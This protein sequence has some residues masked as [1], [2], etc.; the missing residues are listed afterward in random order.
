MSYLI[1]IVG[2]TASGKTSTAI[3][4]ARAFDTVVLSADSRQ[5]YKEMS[6]GTAKPN[7]V[8][9]SSAKHYFIDNLSI[10]D[11]YS[12]GNYEREV[13]ALLD[14]LF[15]E[16]EVIVM[17][18]GSGLFINAV[19]YGLD[20]FPDVPVEIRDKYI[21]LEKEKGISHLQSLLKEKDPDYFREVDIDNPHRLIRALAVIEVSNMPF[22]SFRNQAPKLRSFN[23]LIINLEWDRKELYDR[24]N[25]RV[26]IMMENGLMK[27]I[28][29]LYPSRHLN[30][31]QTVG[32]KEL[33]DYKMGIHDLETA[34]NL[35][36][37]NSRRYAKRQLTWIRKMKEVHHFPAKD[38][39]RILEFLQD[40]I[41]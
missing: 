5:F 41:I 35:I 20:E 7:D 33:F 12:V 37:R 36:K 3:E 2:P 8:E 32:Y 17:A 21:E 30:A 38:T 39:N 28:E 27:E 10:E 15:K 11:K 29:T 34:I 22:S 24:I 14:D 26:D 23:P 13:I 16:K 1:V 18:G 25:T 40:K 19:L 9:L 4:I 31:L 6:I